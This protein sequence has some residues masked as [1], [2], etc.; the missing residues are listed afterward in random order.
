M[1]TDS[2]IKEDVINELKW[3][4]SVNDTNIRVVVKNGVVTLG[5]PVDSYGEKL[6]AEDAALRVSDVKAVVNEINVNLPSTSVRSD[7]DIARAALNAIK[8]NTIVPYDRIKVAVENGTVTLSGK[9]DWQYQ[10]EIAQ[11]VVC[12][13]WG[14]RAVCNDITV[15]PKV[16]PTDVKAKIR[17]ALQ[18]NAMLDAQRITV[19]ISDNKVVLSGSVRSWVERDEAEKAAWA[20]PG[21]SDVDN[22]ITIGP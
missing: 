11:N 20:A 13:L 1:R 3:E 18:R 16:K 4:P 22:R 14:V 2:E 19:E 7:E 12:N 17:S 21:V 15:K 9:V 6:S 10:K 5:G 8:W